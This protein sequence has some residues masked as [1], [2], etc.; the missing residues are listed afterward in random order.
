MAVTPFITDAEATQKIQQSYSQL[1]SR[2]NDIESGGWNTLRYDIGKSW[3][4]VGHSIWWQDGL[5]YPSTSTIAVGT[6]TLVKE[7]VTFTDYNKYAYSGRSLAGTSDS[8]TQSILQQKSVWVS[9]DIWTFDSITNDFK[10][11][12][13]IG[14]ENDFLNNTGITTFY[15]A[16]RLFHDRMKE[17]NPN[18]LCICASPLQRDYS[19]Y[20][21]WSKNTLDHSLKD[22]TDALLWVANRL[23]WRFVDQ[24]NYS[25]I[26]IDNL[27]VNTRDGLHPN[28]IGYAKYAGLWINEFFKI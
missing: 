5:A 18:Y 10:L 8:D 13:P 11:N 7:K 2:I 20:T 6:Q 28:N 15:G 9:A 19:G 24:F 12:R 17:L 3:N 25:G 1:E 26:N 14:T 23:S 27:G 21:S 16:L 4:A 22:Y